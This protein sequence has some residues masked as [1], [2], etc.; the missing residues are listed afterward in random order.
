MDA[1]KTITTLQGYLIEPEKIINNRYSLFENLYDLMRDS[2][3]T[4]YQQREIHDLFKAIFSFFFEP[5]RESMSAWECLETEFDLQDEEDRFG[6]WK[7]LIKDF[8]SKPKLRYT[9]QDFQCYI[10]EM[11]EMESPESSRMFVGLCRLYKNAHFP[12]FRKCNYD[13]YVERIS[14]EIV[15]IPQLQTNLSDTQRMAL[16]EALK[17]QNAIDNSTDEASFLWAFGGSEIPP[18]YTPILWTLK[19]KISLRELLLTPVNDW[20]ILYQEIP[21]GIKPEE[22]EIEMPESVRRI[23]KKLFTY[24]NRKT[25]IV[26]ELELNK[27]KG[28]SADIRT[29]EGILKNLPTT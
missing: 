17:E 1:R 5:L 7:Y 25:S 4:S 23:I 8:S 2:T 18:R 9:W 22:V 6:D 27:P 24:T 29:I 28:Y 10:S 20:Q 15:T 12:T 19:S 13:E 11:P 14:K 26:E 3:V 21:E 16:F